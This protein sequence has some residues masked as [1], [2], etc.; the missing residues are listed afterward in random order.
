MFNLTLYVFVLC[1][2]VYFEPKSDKETMAKDTLRQE[3]PDVSTNELVMGAVVLRN[4]EE[5]ISWPPGSLCT[6]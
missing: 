6:K 5:G 1:L 3:R 2:N 4:L